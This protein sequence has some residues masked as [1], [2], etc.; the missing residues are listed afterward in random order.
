MKKILLTI[1]MVLTVT[2]AFAVA[3]T[4]Q[5][6][7]KVDYSGFVK[8][9]GA[10]SVDANGKA[11]PGEESRNVECNFAA[12][13]KT[14]T[15]LINWMFYISIPIAA[16]L[17]A[18]GGVLY[19]TGEPGKINQAKKIFTSVGIGFIIMAI[20]WVGVVQALSFFVKDAWKPTTETFLKK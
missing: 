13:V 12:L 4:T 10:V 15:S 19:I 17:F 5:T 1:L 2:P 16:T 7:P 8:C 18:Y 14:I 3:Q 6:P 9:D 11:N 20:A